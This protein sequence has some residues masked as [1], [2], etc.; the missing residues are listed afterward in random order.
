LYLASPFSKASL[1]TS[2]EYFDQIY[3]QIIDYAVKFLKGENTLAYY[4]KQYIRVQ[5][6]L[7]IYYKICLGQSVP[8]KKPISGKPY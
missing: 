5:M 6:A 7:F 4:S 2:L 3:L 8:N 1:D